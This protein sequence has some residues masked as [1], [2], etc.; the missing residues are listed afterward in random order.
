MKFKFSFEALLKQRKRLEN[1]AQIVYAEAQAEANAVLNEIEAMYTKIEDSRKRI[2]D[3]SET[4]GG[5][6]KEAINIGDYIELVKVKIEL[7]KVEARELL[8]IAE[9]KKE[10]LLEASKEYKI[11]S[12]LKEKKE[13]AFRKLKNKKEQKFLDEISIINFNHRGSYE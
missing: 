11:I 4:D 7:K 1:Q 9:D 5:F 10:L 3:L 12:K 6:S 8:S 2:Q 13:L